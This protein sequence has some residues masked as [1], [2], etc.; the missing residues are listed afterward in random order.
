M[1]VLPRLSALFLHAVNQPRFAFTKGGGRT[2]QGVKTTEVKFQEKGVPTIIRSSTG[3]DAPSSGSFWIDP[4]T[5]AVLG[6][7]LKNGDSS[8][9]YDELTITYALDPAT[10]LWLPA[11]LAEKMYDSQDEKE[12]D[13]KGTFKGWRFAPRGK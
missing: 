11:S 5:G 4:A 2:I 13:G 9:L 8:A 3:Q 6:S 10:G 12:I 7:F 1:V